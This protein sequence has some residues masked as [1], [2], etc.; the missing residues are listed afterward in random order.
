[1]QTTPVFLP[2]KPQEQ[3]EKAKRQDSRGEPLRSAGV[4]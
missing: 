2:Q 3:Y 1:M 4:Q